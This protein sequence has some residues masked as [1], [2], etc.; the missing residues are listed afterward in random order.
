MQGGVR[1][2][3]LAD[4]KRANRTTVGARETLRAITQGNVKA[5][6]V[7]DDAETHITVG[8]LGACED[9]S[10]PII[11]VES[12]AALGKAAGVQVRSAVAAILRD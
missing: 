11:H 2:T 8:I 5:V 6:F 1:L 10:I 12:M 3:D 7:A 9:K 4:L